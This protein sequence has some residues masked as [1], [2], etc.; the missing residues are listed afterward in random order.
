MALTYRQQLIDLS[1][2]LYK[3][4][5]LPPQRSPMWYFNRVHSIGASEIGTLRGENHYETIHDLIMGHIGLKK[6][7]NMIPLHWG[8]IMENCVTMLIEIIFGCTIH[9]TGSIPTPG[10]TGQRCSPDGVAL[11][12]CLGN[13]IISFEIKAPTN[14]L[15]ASGRIPASY[16]SQVLACL[17][18]VEPSNMGIFVDTSLRRCSAEQWTFDSAEYDTTFH[19]PVNFPKA[20]ALT[21]LHFYK[22]IT[23]DDEPT[24]DDVICFGDCPAKEFEE[25]LIAVADKKIVKHSYGQVYPRG[26]NL[27]PCLSDEVNRK[28]HELGDEYFYL[29]YL[30][31]KLLRCEV[32]PVAKEPDFVQ[33]NA[34]K[35]NIVLEIIRTVLELPEDQRVDEVDR[36]V[37]EHDL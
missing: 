33:E 26:A 35:I 8:C 7:S 32:M 2:F 24:R 17:C 29:G 1:L 3:W 30:P 22:K 5:D 18:A 16:R 11:V 31:L 36:L 6:I 4:K 27:S 34:K 9:E 15:P 21:T 28:Y 19:R 13:L 23:L 20:L 12:R 10:V 25:L 14:R 37:A